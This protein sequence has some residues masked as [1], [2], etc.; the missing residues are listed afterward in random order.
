M[1]FGSGVVRP[2]SSMISGAVHADFR[3]IVMLV[4]QLSTTHILMAY[5]THLWQNLGWCT[6]V[7][8][9]LNKSSQVP[10]QSFSPK[11]RMMKLGLPRNVLPW[12]QVPDRLSSH[13]G[14]KRKR[15]HDAKSVK[16][17][18]D[19]KSL[20]LPTPHK[21]HVQHPTI[22][23]AN[24][25]YALKTIR[26]N[27]IIYCAQRESKKHSPFYHR[28]ELAKDSANYKIIIQ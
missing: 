4:K 7:L 24:P 28:R 16:I 11:P 23:I 13:S 2:K 12:Q 19:E 22:R 10:F 21:K 14:P 9:T 26:S 25:S 17:V 20:L 8:P 5:T 6:V 27:Y 15:C 1:F 3:T 18:V